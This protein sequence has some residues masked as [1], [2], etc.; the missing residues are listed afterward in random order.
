MKNILYLSFKIFL[1][2]SIKGLW[3]LSGITLGISILVFSF[4][5]MDG[6]REGMDSTLRKIYPPI[7]IKGNIN[8][9]IPASVKEKGEVIAEVFFEGLAISKKDNLSK[10]VFVRASEK[11]SK[12]ALGKTLA[13]NLKISKGDSLFLVYKGKTSQQIINLKV[14][15]IQKTGLSFVDESLIILPL[16]LL[17]DKSPSYGIYPKNKKNL[18]DIQ[19]ILKSETLWAP[20]T[21]EEITKDLLQPLKI[22]EWSIGLI[23]SLITMV[24]SFHLLTKLLLDMRERKKTFAI[25]Y[26]LG[27]KP[28]RIFLS[29]FFYSFFLGITGVIS[30]ILLGVS[31]IYL[32][33]RIHLFA[34]KGALKGVYF[35]EEI[36][37]KIFPE[38]LTFIFLLGT[39]IILFIS[40][41][42]F[43]VINKMKIVESLRYE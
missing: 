21:F 10:F 7:Y 20:V 5:L 35:L 1:K 30:G 23:L 22:V 11:N 26:A 39:G 17:K 31:A 29:F 13:E 9:E 19:E 43:F 8:L 34:F 32:S 24:S 2:G 40:F 4:A 33:N 41:I 3:C 36:T 6:Y 18:K 27:M 15:E 42:T 37:L 25:L 14:E 38:S 12:V 16:N 28:S